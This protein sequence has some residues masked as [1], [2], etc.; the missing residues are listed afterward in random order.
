MY[1]VS[2]FILKMEAAT[3]PK[4][5]ANYST[6]TQCHHQKMEM[7]VYILR[8]SSVF[9]LTSGRHDKKLFK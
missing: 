7:R 1:A 9:P 6:T 5:V 8:N 2:H 4:A 3:F